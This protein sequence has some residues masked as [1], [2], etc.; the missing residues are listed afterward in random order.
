[1]EIVGNETAVIDHQ[2]TIGLLKRAFLYARPD[3]SEAAQRLTLDATIEELGI[4]SIAALEMSGFIEEQ[5][6]VQFP[7]DELVGIRS[8]R[9]LAQLV[10]KYEHR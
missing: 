6:D 4:D 7:D 1:M 5:I 3:H 2:D 8:M 9:D 10:R